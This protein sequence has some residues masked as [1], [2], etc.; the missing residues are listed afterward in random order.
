MLGAR[1]FRQISGRSASRRTP[2]C[3]QLSTASNVTL[4]NKM[5]TIYKPVISSAFSLCSLRQ[6]STVANPAELREQWGT[7]TLNV[8]ALTKILDHDNLEMRDKFRI[9]M[10]DPVMAPKYNISLSD[11]REVALR[12]LKAICDAGFISVLDFWNNPLRIF[13]AHEIAS[14]VDP[15]MATKMTVQFNLFGG[16]VL[17]LGTERHHKKLLKG[18]DTLDDVGC[19]GL[20]ELGYGNNAVEMETTAIYDK[21]TQEFIVNTPTT[22]AQKY[23]ITNGAIHA[24]HIIV[25]SQLSV[26]GTNRGIHGVLVQIRDDNMKVLPGVT[27]EDMGFKMGLNGVDNAKLSFDNVRVPRE[28]LL[29]KYSDVEA[30]GTFTTSIASDRARF[31]TVADQLLSGRTCIASMSQGGSKAALAIAIRYSAT[32]LTV[33]P[34]GKSDAPIMSYQLQQ[35]ALL[36]LLART[37]AI[38]F[39]LDYVKD[40]WAFQAKDGSEHAA[41]VSMCC[42]IKPLASWN[43][44]KVATVCRERCGGQGY[45][46]CNR[47]GTIIGLAHAAMTA[48]GDNSVLMQKVAKERLVVFKPSASAA[49]PTTNVTSIEY[50]QWVLMKREDVL[51]TE[52]GK[53]MKAAGKAAMFSTWMYEKS[54]LI[55]GAGLSFGERMCSEQFSAVISSAESSLQHVLS[56][57]HHLYLLDCVERD[58]GNLIINGVL[59]LDVAKQVKAES[60]KVCAQL[61]PYALQLVDAFGITEDM[62]SAP[63]ARDW[64]SYN[65]YDNQGEVVQA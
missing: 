26:E 23:W 41:V 53:A 27:V 48:E 6:Q 39:G 58:L 1:L 45:L 40:R 61:G 29:N 7:I 62:L 20:T 16:T 14:I 25:F 9:F 55:Q 5:P 13:A 15:A 38:N 12:R 64:V 2:I 21:E 44:E 8:P 19:F 11:E 54:D 18:I 42:A 52:L 32:R 33:G 49:P 50:L 46:S 4:D 47:F 10:S 37:Y 30:D 24:K 56:D 17:K 34:N 63:I 36:P 51:F 43:L 3:T 57:L 60:Q 35:R 59:P 65:A 28:N 22:M 31:L